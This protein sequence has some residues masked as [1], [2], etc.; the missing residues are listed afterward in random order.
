MASDFGLI[1]R[2]LR[3]DNRPDLSGSWLAPKQKN[4]DEIIDAWA[5]LSVALNSINRSMGLPDIYPF[6]LSKD[7]VEK[8]RF[9]SDVIAGSQVETV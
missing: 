8:L 4:F 2:R 1:S 6:V 3:L 9:I 5:Q 7:V